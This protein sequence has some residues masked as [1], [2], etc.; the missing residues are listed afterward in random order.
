[1]FPRF[2][3]RSR[4]TFT[5]PRTVRYQEIESRVVKWV[6][7][8]AARYHEEELLQQWEPGHEDLLE[9]ADEPEK[10]LVSLRPQVILADNQGSIKMTENGLGNTR[11]KHI[12]LQYHYVR[13]TWQDGKII[14]QYE[15]TETMTA[16]I[17]TNP[18]ARDRHWTLMRA[19]GLS[20]GIGEET[21]K[22]SHAR[23]I[24]LQ[25]GNTL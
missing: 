8:D 16:D 17:M 20:P 6:V 19:M 23:H 18:L 21:R 12:D 15:P 11:A 25:V 10:R 9:P 22:E 24:V 4:T 5:V 14:L 1:M 2:S 3:K 13:D 7:L